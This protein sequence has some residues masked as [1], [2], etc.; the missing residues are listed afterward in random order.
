M[1]FGLASVLI[2][3]VQ[4]N[5]LAED[6]VA[7]TKVADFSRFGKLSPYFVKG[8]LLT[9]RISKFAHLPF[10]LHCP[11]GAPGRILHS[12]NR[13][14]FLHMISVIC[15]IFVF[16]CDLLH[17]RHFRGAFWN[18]DQF[19]SVGFSRIPDKLRISCK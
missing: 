12:P 10:N 9:G 1:D 6:I 8:F 14:I 5:S 4:L 17:F 15:V 19:D 2:I 11:A 13:E 16:F 3:D 7:V 18:A